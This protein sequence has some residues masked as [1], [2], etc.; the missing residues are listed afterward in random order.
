MLHKGR[1]WVST[2]RAAKMLRMSRFTLAHALAQGDFGFDVHT[3]PDKI[4][5]L[6]HYLRLDQVLAQLGGARDEVAGIR[7]ETDTPRKRF[8]RP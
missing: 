1:V 3:V 7:K 5:R 4:G 2:G 8:W 6:R